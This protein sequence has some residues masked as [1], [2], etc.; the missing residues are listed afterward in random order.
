[1]RPH[2]LIPAK[3]SRTTPGRVVTRSGYAK[4]ATQRSRPVLPPRIARRTLAIG[5]VLVT[6]CTASSGVGDR[7]NEGKSRESTKSHE[8]VGHA[9]V[10]DGDTLEIR[11]T[12]IRLHGVDA[13][14]SSQACEDPAHKSYRCGQR[15]ALELADWL[16]QRTVHCGVVTKD[17]YERSVARCTVGDSDI[18][19]WLVRSGRAM[20]YRKYS[21][22]YV[23]EEDAARKAR[24]G[25]WAGTF[26]PPWEYRSAKRNASSAN[27]PSSDARGCKI[28]GN[29]SGDGERVY[30]VP[31]D[32]S[33]ERTV[34]TMS[35][36]E[37]WFCSEPEARKA[38]WKRAAD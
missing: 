2:V 12:R 4:E 34:I 7:H 3:A 10:I 23:G 35:K 15:A 36:G 22:V 5:V 31:G 33:Y 19:A 28:K 38:G 6:G 14:E 18:G 25:I 11:N 20:A 27:A 8:I 32:H 13:P 37:R 16:Q 21:T 9:T 24:R 26:Q 1:M 30:H 29:I 17:R